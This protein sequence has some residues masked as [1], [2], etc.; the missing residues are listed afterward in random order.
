MKIGQRD[1]SAEAPPYVIAEIG[2]NHDGSLERAFELVDA[3]AD[4]G[5]DAVKVQFFQADLLMSAAAAL[6][7]YQRAA[8]ERDPRDML[9]RLELSWPQLAAIAER[10]RLRGLHAIATVFSVSLVP[11]AQR[12]GFDAFKAASPDIVH[13]P[14][15]DALAASGK[16]LI[17]SAGAADAQEIQRARD[18]LSGADT[19]F[20]HCVSA[21]PT[22]PEAATLSAMSDL[23]RLTGRP[24]GYSDH[25]TLVET[26]ALAVAAGGIALEKHLTHNRA[27]PGPDHAASL[28]PAQFREYVR[29]T[30]LAHTMRGDGLKR[31][32]PIEENVR[33]VSRQSIVAARAIR[34]GEV[35]DASMLTC[36]RPG[37]GFEPWRLPELIGRG[38]ARD[39]P[40]DAPIRPEDLA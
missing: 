9:R 2:V 37:G 23:A 15:L 20:L 40:P 3:A 18:W 31:V 12:L 19:I 38:A 34:R 16:P 24:V 17:I 11:E 33:R 4:A 25:T 32:L 26:G 29:L 36:K 10:T 14:L 27:A 5:A 7:D 1:I 22:P 39:L 6:A 30:R 21:Y 8:G 13:R 35:L 28:D